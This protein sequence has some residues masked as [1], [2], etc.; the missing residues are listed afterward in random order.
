MNLDERVASAKMH[1]RLR[2][3]LAVGGA[4]AAAAVVVAGVDGMTGDRSAGI[5]PVDRPSVTTTGSTRTGRVDTSTWTRYT[6]GRYDLEVGH[7]ADWVVVPATRNW[8]SD[9]DMADPLSPAHEDFRSPAKDVRVSVWSMPLGAARTSVCGDATDR[10]CVESIRFLRAWVKEYCKASKN[11]P[12]VGIEDRAV[13][14]CV[15]KWDCHP[16]LLVRF[17]DDVQA[18]F[19]GGI[20][21][22][23]AMT[24]VA[25]WASEPDP[26]LARYSGAQKLLESFLSTMQ[27]WPASTPVDQRQ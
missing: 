13:E 15:E 3:A 21:D 1:S 6:S 5:A 4:V 16:G 10:A 22:P 19:S 14:L 18:F 26:H 7:P 9:G 11:S 24:V 27:V 17:K 23:E 12:C 20:Y 25:L 2:G 8:R